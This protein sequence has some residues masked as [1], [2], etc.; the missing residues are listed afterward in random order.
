MTTERVGGQFTRNLFGLQKSEKDHSNSE[1]LRCMM[2]SLIQPISYFQGPAY[3]SAD[4]EVGKYFE[5][6]FPYE[7]QRVDNFYAQL[8][9]NEQVKA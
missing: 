2:R 5:F 8:N 3:S 6:A 4:I 7:Q 9:I 1:F